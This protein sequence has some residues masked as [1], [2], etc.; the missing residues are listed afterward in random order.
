MV[1]RLVEQGKMWVDQP[2][3]AMLLS[4]GI[5]GDQQPGDQQHVGGSSPCRQDHGDTAST[6]GEVEG[7]IPSSPPV[8]QTFRNS[9]RDA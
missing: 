3:V 7:G 5:P 1:G 2:A 8:D 6:G 4:P 9:A